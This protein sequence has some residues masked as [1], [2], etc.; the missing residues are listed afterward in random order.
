MPDLV[1]EPHFHA[2]KAFVSASGAGRET[3]QAGWLF[4]GMDRDQHGEIRDATVTDTD[5]LLAEAG[6][7]AD[8]IAALRKEGVA[9]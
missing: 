8:E 9:A 1:A 5:A 3:E 6:Y 7:S 2:R 4:A